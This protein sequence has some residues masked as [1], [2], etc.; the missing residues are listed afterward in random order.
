[1]A[2]SL[3]SKL[4]CILATA[5]GNGQFLSIKVFSGGNSSQHV[6][7][8][9][10]HECLHPWQRPWQQPCMNIL[11]SAMNIQLSMLPMNLS[12]PYSTI[13]HL[14]PLFLVQ[15]KD[16]VSQAKSCLPQYM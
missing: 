16:E 4:S 7:V 15:L 3:A 10:L 6:H 12:F 2:R 14:L 9:V 1:M 11:T 8:P 5:K 13:E